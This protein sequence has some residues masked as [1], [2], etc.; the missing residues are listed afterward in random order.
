MMRMKRRF[1]PLVAVIVGCFAGTMIDDAAFAQTGPDNG[2]RPSD[3]RHDALTHAT[4]VVSPDVTLVDATVVLK[5]GVIVAVGELVAVPE[6]AR[7]WDCTGLHIYPGLIE[8]ALFVDMSGPTRGAGSHWNP[9]VHP[10]WNVADS[11]APDAALRKSLRALGFTAA[12]VYPAAGAFKGTGAIVALGDDDKDLLTYTERGPMAMQLEY[13]GGWSEPTYPAAAMGSVALVRQTLYDANWYGASRR[14]YANARDGNEPPIRADALAALQD[15]IMHRQPIVCRTRDEHDA[16]RAAATLREFDLDATLVGS[17]TEYRRLSELTEIGW[18]IIV[19]VDFPERP[20]ISSPSAADNVTLR[21]LQ[22][23]EQAP[24]NPQRLIRAGLPVALTTHGLKKRSEFDARIRDAKKAGLTDAEALAALTTSPAAMLGL[25]HVM[26]T[27]TPGMVANLIVVDGPLFEKKTKR[28]DTW[29]NG[30]RYEIEARPALTLDGP[31]TFAVR[32]LD[33]SLDAKLNT[34]KST[35]SVDLDE[36][37][38]VKASKVEILNDQFSAVIDGRIVGADGYAVLSGTMTSSGVT[39]AIALPSG[40]RLRFTLTM[41]DDDETADDENDENDADD[42]DDAANDDDASD[43][44]EA[45]DDGENDSKKDGDKDDDAKDD[46]ADVEPPAEHFN[47]PLGAYGL[48]APPTAQSV[49]ITNATIWPCN[50]EP[51]L[52]NAWMH[53]ADGRIQ[54]VS[55]GTGLDIDADVVID[56]TGKHITPGLIDCH[57][58]TGIFGGVNEWTQT[59]SAEVRIADCI[60]PDDVN[61]YRELAGGLTAANQLHGSANPIGGQNSVVKLKWGSPAGAFPIEDAMPGI[62]F[63]LGENVK[64]SS[65]RYPDTRMGVETFI[66]DAFTAAVDYRAEHE[67]YAALSDSARQRTM[68]PRRDLELDTMVEILEGSRIIHCHS[69]R[70]DEILMLIR[71]ADEFGFTIGTFQHVLEGYK[72]ADDIAKHGA[73]GSSFSDWWMYKV[74]VMD[75][76]PHNGALMTSVGVLTS[77]NSDSNEL[78]RRMNIEAAKAVR[79]GDMAPHEALLL[80][81]L[82]PA[83]QLRVDHRIGSLEAGKDADFVVWSGDPLSVYSRCE[84]TWI[85]GARLF[86]LETDRVLRAEADAER[87]RLI[88]RVLADAHGSPGKDEAPV[89]EGPATQPAGVDAPGVPESVAAANDLPPG[90]SAWFVDQMRRGNAPD[91]VHPGDCGCLM[92]DLLERTGM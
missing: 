10:E 47:L 60:N 55:D 71:L 42:E 15:V 74:E 1:A 87:Q 66:R 28:Y 4:V 78:A 91:M 33:V 70:Q 89:T 12:A 29:I 69:Y 56:G 24:T 8:S 25:E 2:M 58:H 32:D 21:T 83:K 73:G 16:R 52:M 65:G 5:D 85:E 49:L 86:D 40:A 77:F 30:R 14:V 38:T 50:G 44:E 88:Q 84:Q 54:V 45:D 76:I 92:H 23:W 57:S 75:A 35:F 13:S 82:N 41:R 19:P 26:G 43:D 51:P 72:V 79:Y 48:S 11:G 64:R 9:R 81:T 7:V 90:V 27:I 37:D 63:A 53:V 67:R 20:D 22:E 39:G 80:V 59:N 18:P 6:G 31:A 68:P 46:D 36:K 17:G 61:W 34:K 62:K 3:I